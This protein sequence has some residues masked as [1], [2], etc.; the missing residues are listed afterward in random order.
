M[1]SLTTANVFPAKYEAILIP[2]EAVMILET[3]ILNGAAY[4]L[5]IP[6][7]KYEMGTHYTI[8]IQVGQDQVNFGSIT[9]TPWEAVYGGGLIAE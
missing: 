9:Q 8:T 6:S 3:Q 5:T 4:Q 2:Q 7:Q 1:K